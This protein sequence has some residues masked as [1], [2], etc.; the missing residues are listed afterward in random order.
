MSDLIL[1]NHLKDVIYQRNTF[2][3]GQLKHLPIISFVIKRT[4]DYFLLSLGSFNMTPLRANC[5][6]KENACT[7][8]IHKIIIIDLFKFYSVKKI[9][10]FTCSLFSQFMIFLIYLQDWSH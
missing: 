4:I 7:A 6:L 8:T 3:R 10:R 5:T 2:T 1:M 9:K